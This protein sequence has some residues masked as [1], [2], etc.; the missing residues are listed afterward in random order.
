[1]GRR[2]ERLGV[3]DGSPQEEGL[4]RRDFVKTC[5]MAAAA[6]G[7]PASAGL[8]WAE[9][10]EAGLKPSVI[11]L[12]FQE[13]TGCT[14]SLLRTSSPGICG[15]DPRPRLA[16]LSRDVVRRCGL[17][18]RRSPA[19]GDGSARRP[20]C[21]R[22]RGRDPEEGRRHLLSDRWTNRDRY[23]RGRC[24]EGG[25]GGCHRFVRLVGRHSVGRSESDRRRWRAAD[26]RGNHSCHDSRLPGESLQLPRNGAPV[27]RPGHAARARRQGPSALRLWAHDPRAL[28]A[29]RALRR[30]PLRASVWRRGAQTRLL[31]LRWAARDRRP[32]PTARFSHFGEVP[33]A[34]P[35][36]IG[37]PCFGCTEQGVAFHKPLHQEAAHCPKTLCRRFT[38]T[39]GPA[40]PPLRQVSPA[41]LVEPWSA[42]G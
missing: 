33:D 15:A 34:W 28:P 31:P 10:A 27:R 1:M 22:G 8:K 18:D 24:L 29:S 9:A 26:P 41:S 13:C 3:P 6:V 12:H 19:P 36:G 37:H 23:P 21:V 20:I 4:G 38:P 17:P 40:R 11:W 35:I 39:I 30:R 2:D 16:G 32:T 5:M 42:P 14:E 7:L 25:R